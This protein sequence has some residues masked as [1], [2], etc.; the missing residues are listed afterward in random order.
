MKKYL[1]LVFIVFFLTGCTTVVREVKDLSEEEKDNI[2]QQVI[3]ELKNQ[4]ENEYRSNITDVEKMISDLFDNEAKAV[5]GVSNYIDVEGIETLQGT[6][7]GV[8]YKKV[9]NSYYLITNEHVVRDADT[10]KVVLQDL[11]TLVAIVIGTDPITD[12]AVIKI[13]T[14]DYYPVVAFKDTNALIPGQF[15][16]AVGNPLGYDYYRSITLGIISGVKRRLDV[17][18]DEDQVID[19]KATLIQH[20]AAI[21]PGNSGGA[22]FDI[23]GNLIGINN[24]KIVS[25]DVSGIGFAIPTHIIKP[26][27]DELEENGKITR[28]SLGIVGV[29]IEKVLGNPNYTIPSGVSKGVFI[30]DIVSNSTVDG[31]DI[32]IKDILIK[33]N[34]VEVS[35]V[36]DIRL[37]LTEYKIGDTVTLTV[38]RNGEQLQV[39][40]V[41]KERP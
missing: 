7:S 9:D 12:L 37:L 33:F 22:L 31:K 28:A 24:M 35:L 8:I 3:D 11:S 13:V 17:D 23:Q 10:I 30:T 5:L 2:K 1:L 26:I 41:L 25:T 27:I 36:E 4:F 34:N 40:V 32:Q 38:L 19:W 14:D 15:A 6:G 16:I 39:D 18:Y 21:S 20:D 29:E